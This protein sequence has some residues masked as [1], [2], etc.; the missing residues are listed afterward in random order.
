M[1]GVF[2][3]LAAVAVVLAASVGDID[4]VVRALRLNITA[5]LQKDQYCNQNSKKTIY[6]CANPSVDP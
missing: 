5:T 3:V 4:D 6:Y 1:R 2:Q